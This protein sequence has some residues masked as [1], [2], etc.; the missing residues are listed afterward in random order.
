MSSDEGL[1]CENH[2]IAHSKL[3]HGFE[4]W[5][6]AIALSWEDYLLQ[7]YEIDGLGKWVQEI[8][9]YIMSQEST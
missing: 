5:K 4:S 2:Q 7:V 1:F 8:I 3:K 9:D 6:E